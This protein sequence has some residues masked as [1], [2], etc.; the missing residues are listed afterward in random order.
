MVNKLLMSFSRLQ[1]ATTTT[2][3]SPPTIAGTNGKF[4]SRRD[5]CAV[6][7]IASAL[8]G[9][10]TGGWHYGIAIVGRS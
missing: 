6:G 1:R 3:S 5:P 10:G 7:L 9:C 4:S 2:Q 8:L